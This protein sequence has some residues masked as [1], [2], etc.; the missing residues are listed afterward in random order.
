MP[1][2]IKCATHGECLQT[3]VCAHLAEGNV[4]LGFNREEPTA[5]DP[6][7]DAWCDNCEI[8]RAAHDGWNEEC[9]KLTKIVMLCSGCYKRAQIRNTNPSVTLDDL[10]DLRWKCGNCD[11]WHT[12]P[13]LD[14]GMDSPH[15]WN[16]EM[17]RQNNFT[18]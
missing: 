4:G 9:E 5:D 7:P 2:N 8:I 16:E 18:R 14:F 15:Y 1:N 6:Y 12:G 10:A 11:E 13:C 17:A 3:F